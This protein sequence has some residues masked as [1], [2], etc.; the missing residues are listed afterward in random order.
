MEA[1]HSTYEASTGSDD[2]V[3]DRIMNVLDGEDESPQEHEDAQDVPD[4]PDSDESAEDE[5]EESTEE[6]ADEDTAEEDD[7]ASLLGVS[8][9]QLSVDEAGNILITTKV[10]G[11]SAQVTLPELV[12]GYQ[13]NKAVTQRSQALAEQRKAFE[14]QAAQV[15]QQLQAEVQKASGLANH[16]SQ[17]M[18]AEF[19][20][21]NWNELREVDPAEYSAK[22]YDYERKQAEL[23]QVINYGQQIQQQQAEQA[24][25]QQMMQMREVL[26]QQREVMLQNNPQWKDPEV[27][28]RDMSELRQFTTDSYGFNDDELENVTDARIIEVLKDAMAYR[29]G[30]KVA[31][32]KRTNAPKLLK[33][34]TPRTKQVSLR[35][36]ARKQRAAMKRNGGDLKSVAAYLESNVL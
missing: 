28:K 5:P 24:Q 10:D 26:A 20:N 23:Q 8:E 7:L 19:Q 35:E 36:Q 30:K 12:K 22:R 29:K 33:P 27:L 15:Q 14:A 31:E 2:A 3:I 16:L 4:G 6:E 9:D 21:I 25:Q 13:L 17:Q 34:G 1:E 11:E 32:K 18:M